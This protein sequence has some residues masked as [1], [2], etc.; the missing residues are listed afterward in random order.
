MCWCFKNYFYLFFPQ[1]APLMF[2]VLNNLNPC[3]TI[4]RGI[5][6]SVFL[7]SPPIQNSRRQSAESPETTAWRH[8]C[9]S[10]AGTSHHICTSTLEFLGLRKDWLPGRR[11][12]RGNISVC[13]VHLSEDLKTSITRSFRGGWSAGSSVLQSWLQKIKIKENWRFV[14]SN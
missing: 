4:S 2:D 7:F 3:Y 8:F 9:Q 10:A 1:T 12:K 11:S 5:S 13:W 14:L 6:L